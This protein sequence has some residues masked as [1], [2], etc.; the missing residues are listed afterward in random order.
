MNN[1]FPCST[2]VGAVRPVLRTGGVNG[3]EECPC[4]PAWLLHVYPSLYPT[5][6]DCSENLKRSVSEST[7]SGIEEVLLEGGGRKNPR[8]QHRVRR[9]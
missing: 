5:D 1:N 3:G 8:G 4:T 9:G 6:N 2:Y 7:G